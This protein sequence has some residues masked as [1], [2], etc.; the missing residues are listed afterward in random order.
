MA[1]TGG[2]ETRR[3]ILTAARVQVATRGIPGL[4]LEGV[5]R[6]VGVTRQAV[7]YHFGSR[8]RLLVEL[9]FDELEQE[10]HALTTAI[11]G[12]GSAPAAIEAFVAAAVDHYLEDL[13]RFRLLYLVHQVARHEVELPPEE[14]RARLYPTT[15]RAFDRL[16]A[17]IR[18]DP[19]LAPDVDPRRIAVAT[20]MAALGVAAYMST[21]DAT[22][23]SLLHDPRVVAAD[24]ARAIGRGIVRSRAGG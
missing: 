6:E 8:Q 16:E 5:A 21:I 17:A 18:A 15:R 13:D 12:A 24:V 23:D 20:H 2:D 19:R 10:A 7:L 22:G 4:T 9:Y 3:R 11:E 1:R 14:R